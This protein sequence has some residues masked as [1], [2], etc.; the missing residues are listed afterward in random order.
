MDASSTGKHNNPDTLV[1]DSV[2][3]VLTKGE[4]VEIRYQLKG[5]T[6]FATATRLIILRYGR[7]SSHEYSKIAAV[8]ETSRS[9]TWFILCGVALFALGG[10]S[11][12]FP[13][14]GAGLILLGVLTQSRRVELLVTGL[15]DAVVLDGSREVLTPL[16]QRLTDRGTRKMP[17]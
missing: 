16:V 3:F 1:P 12:A 9:N 6:A 15:K 2:R 7:V 8:R 5:A 17:G 13:V 14:A 10:M 11:A 4:E